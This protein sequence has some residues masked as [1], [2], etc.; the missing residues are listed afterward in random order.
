MAPQCPQAKI[1]TLQNLQGDTRKVFQKGHLLISQTSSSQT[2][3]ASWNQSLP[4]LW[5][6]CRGPIRL[7]SLPWALHMRLSLSRTLCTSPASSGQYTDS[8]HVSFWKSSSF[9]ISLW[10]PSQPHSLQSR[11]TAFS[12][13]SVTHTSKTI[14]PIAMNSYLYCKTVEFPEDKMSHSLYPWPSAQALAYN[15]C[16]IMDFLVV[17]VMIKAPRYWG[18]TC[19]GFKY[20][21]LYKTTI[22]MPI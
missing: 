11:L 20:S 1:Q 2:T 4:S 5:N 14:A 6:P 13:H 10:P 18:L 7:H 9:R 3:S 12:M 16:S 17:V 15:T 21:L 8:L 22:I 19:K